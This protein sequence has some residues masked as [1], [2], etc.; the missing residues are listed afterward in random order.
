MT[1]MT[2][3]VNRMDVTKYFLGERNGKPMTALERKHRIISNA[4][5]VRLFS[6]I[7]RLWTITRKDSAMEVLKRSIINVPVERFITQSVTCVITSLR[8]ELTNLR[9]ES[10]DMKVRRSHAQCV[11]GFAIAERNS[12]MRRN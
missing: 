11:N 4:R 12:N 9:V 1:A 5:T 6:P 2:G 10:V 7:A 3:I 8:V